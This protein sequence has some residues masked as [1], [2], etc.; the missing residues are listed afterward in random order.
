MPSLVPLLC[1]AAAEHCFNMHQ[2]LQPAADVLRP[3]LL[4][5]PHLCYTQVLYSTNLVA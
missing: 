1:R 4:S 3:V 5:R 2:G